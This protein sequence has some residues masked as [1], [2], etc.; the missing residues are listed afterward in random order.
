MSELKQASASGYMILTATSWP[1]P[2]SRARWHC[3]ME[4]EPRGCSASNDSK[5]SSSGGGG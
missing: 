2:L 1:E 4:A 5:T 3:P